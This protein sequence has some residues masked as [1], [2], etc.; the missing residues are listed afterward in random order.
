MVT[1]VVS[2]AIMSWARARTLSSHQLR[3]VERVEVGLTG[4]TKS[5]PS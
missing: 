3:L 1:M 5:S 2:S 4:M